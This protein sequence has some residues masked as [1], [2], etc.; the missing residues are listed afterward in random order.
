MA[1][2][3][4][5]IRV[6]VCDRCKKDMDILPEGD[7]RKSDAEPRWVI[8]AFGN[9][10]EYRDTCKR[11]DGVLRKMFEKITLDHDIELPEVTF[12]TSRTMFDE[13]REEEV[14]KSNAA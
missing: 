13:I 10:Y 14:P 12:D 7:T 4:R 1:I 6:R 8:E 11:C 3:E 9:R 5:T 2:E